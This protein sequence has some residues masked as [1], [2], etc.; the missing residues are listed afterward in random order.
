VR[1]DEP[2]KNWK[3]SMA[4]IEKRKFWT[5]YRDAFE[6]C[7]SETS[8][9]TSPWYVVPADDKEGARLVVSQIVLDTLGGQ[10][11]RY[12]K[13][14]TDRRNELLEIHNQ[15]AKPEEPPSNP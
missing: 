4:D 1:I 6:K 13:T 9:D 14:I 12:P 5:K 7:L 10:E 8:T 2:D 3:F 11:L 15:L